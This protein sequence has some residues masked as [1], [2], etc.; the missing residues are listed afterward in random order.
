MTNRNDAKII[1]QLAFEAAGAKG[2][3]TERGQLRPFGVEANDQFI[4]L[5][6]WSTGKDVNDAQRVA[7]VVSRNESEAVTPREM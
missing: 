1:V 2:K 4:A 6:G 5:V 7:V 3:V